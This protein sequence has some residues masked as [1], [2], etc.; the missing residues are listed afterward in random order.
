MGNWG[1]GHEMGT[2]TRII[3]KI[4]PEKRCCDLNYDIFFLPYC[5][6]VRG[7]EF[8]GQAGLDFRFQGGQSKRLQ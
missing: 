8:P 4:N 3:I 2:Y 5:W 1:Q 6:V 7:T